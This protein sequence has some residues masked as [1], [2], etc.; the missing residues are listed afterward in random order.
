ML[1][2]EELQEYIEHAVTGKRLSLHCSETHQLIAEL[3]S[4]GHHA[5]FSMESMES[6]YDQVWLELPEVKIKHRY[7]IRSKD[8]L[9]LDCN[10][11]V[12]GSIT[13]NYT[14]TNAISNGDWD[15]LDVFWD[16]DATIQLK[17]GDRWIPPPEYTSAKGSNNPWG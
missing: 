13:A 1:S 15:G 6:S 16:H 11:R 14:I 10:G 5:R 2:K 4:L 7:I 8:L 17:I 9:E 3:V 12:V